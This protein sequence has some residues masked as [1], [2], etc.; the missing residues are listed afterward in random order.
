MVGSLVLLGLLFGPLVVIL[1]LSTFGRRRLILYANKRDWSEQHIVAKTFPFVQRAIA[2]RNARRVEQME[3]RRHT[4][5]LRDAETRR[6]SERA[7]N[8][9]TVVRGYFPDDQVTCSLGHVVGCA[10]CSHHANT[11]VL[12]WHDAR[13]RGDDQISKFSWPVSQAFCPHCG[14]ALTPGKFDLLPDAVQYLSKEKATVST[15]HGLIWMRE[16]WGRENELALER[17]HEVVVRLEAKPVEDEEPPAPPTDEEEIEVDIEP[18]DPP[19]H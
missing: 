18:D 8:M 17:L 6:L 2:F 12:S 4:Q 3:Q 10:I 9:L 5:A 16:A 13:P 15:L 11:V 1:Y 19:V 14:A 7:E